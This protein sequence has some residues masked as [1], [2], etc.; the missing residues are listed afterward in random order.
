MNI[1]TDLTEWQRFRNDYSA[2]SL[3][4][5]PTMGNLHA[6]HMSLCERSKTE[7]EVTVVS[8]F[9]NPTQFNQPADFEK[10]PRTINQ[11]ME[12]LAASQIDCLLLPPSNALYPD[13]YQ[14]QV[15]EIELSQELEG[16]FRPGHF[17][18]MLTVVLKL[19]NIVKPTRSY[20]GEK[21]FQQLLLIKKMV[22]ALFLATE[23]VSCA[24]I[25]ADDGLALSSRNVRLN[26]AQRKLAAHFPRLLQS[27]LDIE[28]IRQE[29]TKLGF[30]VDYIAEKWQRRLAAV[31]LGDVR[32]I[33]NVKIA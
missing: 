21:D 1:I 17:K 25:R 30:Q 5:V 31:W 10:Y 14:I 3:G 19:L 4:F 8:I 29:L 6:G 7:N 26:A 28:N 12:L 24:T 11:D 22:D 2:K 16:K 13:D 9:V 23:I 33:D 18:G 15:D 27:S 32:L 20:F